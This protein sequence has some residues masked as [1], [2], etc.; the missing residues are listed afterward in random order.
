M[1][2]WCEGGGRDEAEVQMEEVFMLNWGW[3]FDIMNRDTIINRINRIEQ[4]SH[5]LL[6]L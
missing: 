1:K 5:L 3:R 4:S 6:V 2:R